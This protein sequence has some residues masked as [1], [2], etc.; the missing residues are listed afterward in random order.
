MKPVTTAVIPMT[1]PV[2]G[3]V[4]AMSAE[5]KANNNYYAYNDKLVLAKIRSAQWLTA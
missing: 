4:C 3:V 1:A 2:L 5:Y